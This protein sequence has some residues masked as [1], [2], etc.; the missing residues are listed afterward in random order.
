MPPQLAI[1]AAV[2]LNFEQPCAD[3]VGEMRRQAFVAE[4]GVSLKR[5]DARIAALA[6]V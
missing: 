1:V 4:P 3:R 5:L 2:S 6:N